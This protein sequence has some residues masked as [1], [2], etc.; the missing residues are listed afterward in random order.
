MAKVKYVGPFA[1]GVDLQVAGAWV[2]ALPGE[3]IEV[4]DAVA[5]S[6]CEQVGNWEAAKAAPP[7]KDG[8]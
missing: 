5:A 6:L 1:E 4:P 8:K 7:A 3:T 2:R